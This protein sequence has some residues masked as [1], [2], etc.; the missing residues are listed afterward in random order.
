MC[1][2]FDLQPIYGFKLLTQKKPTCVP[3]SIYSLSIA[4]ELRNSKNNH[5]KLVPQ[6]RF[7]TRYTMYRKL[8]RP[9]SRPERQGNFSLPDFD[10]RVVDLMKRRYTYHRY[11]KFKMSSLPPISFVWALGFNRCIEETGF[12]SLSGF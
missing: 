10:S 2:T 7:T 1:S 11:S 5:I 6:T 3:H 4:F 12:G 8:C 9:R